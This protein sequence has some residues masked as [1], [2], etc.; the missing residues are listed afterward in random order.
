MFLVL[1]HTLYKRAF[2][3]PNQQRVLN[4]PG[5]PRF[6]F[7]VFNFPGGL[8]TAKGHNYVDAGFK[9]SSLKEQEEN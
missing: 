7:E 3:S 4:I 1:L 2:F 9:S 8:G 6:R 5:R